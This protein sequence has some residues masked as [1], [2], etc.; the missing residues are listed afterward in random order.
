L[1]ILRRHQIRTRRYTAELG[2]VV[3]GR[4]DEVQTRRWTVEI[5]SQTQ[6]SL[7][8][9]A[10]QLPGG[11]QR[12]RTSDDELNMRQLFKEGDV[13]VAEVRRFVPRCMSSI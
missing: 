5:G 4:V 3:V 11:I 2:D 7:Q 9:S 10:V 12:R 8:L 1:E 13:V 6:S